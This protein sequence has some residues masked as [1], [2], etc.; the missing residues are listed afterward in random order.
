MHTTS[1]KTKD[2]QTLIGVIKKFRPVEG[3]FTIVLFEEKFN[4]ITVALDTII[5]AITET[6]RG[7]PCK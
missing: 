5:S 2:G 3:F 1:I 7:G 4:E 6:E